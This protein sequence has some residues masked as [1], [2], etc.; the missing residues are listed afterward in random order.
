MNV[1]GNIQILSYKNTLIVD[2]DTTLISEKDSSGS[3]WHC[4]L[5]DVYMNI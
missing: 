3:V 1:I 4:L 2:I 5:E